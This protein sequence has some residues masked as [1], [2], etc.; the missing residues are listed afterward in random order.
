MAGRTVDIEALL[1]A[2]E[3]FSRQRERQLVAESIAMLSAKEIACGIELFG[4]HGG[5]LEARHRSRNGITRGALVGEEG[6]GAQGNELGLVVHVL[7][8]SGHEEQGGQS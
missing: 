6:V 8:A 2:I 3:H 7:P 5:V 1:P 4:V